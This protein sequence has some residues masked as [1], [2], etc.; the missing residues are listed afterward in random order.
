M[1]F[2]FNRDTNLQFSQICVHPQDIG[3][4]EGPKTGMFAIFGPSVKRFKNR[5]FD[6]G[7][8]LQ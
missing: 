6:N 1:F 8:K 2:V 3:G 5:Y 7:R 4:A